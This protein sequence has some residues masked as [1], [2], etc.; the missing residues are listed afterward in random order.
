[1]GLLSFLNKLGEN[2]TEKNKKKDNYGLSKEEQKIVNK[3]GYDSWNF[4]EDDI[5]DEDDYY[6]EDED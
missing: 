1:M 4:E 6:G 3:E 2:E 5:T